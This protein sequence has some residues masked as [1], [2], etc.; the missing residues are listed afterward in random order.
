MH[1]L[2]LQAKVHVLDVSVVHITMVVVVVHVVMVHVVT[3]FIVT[4]FMS[5][6]ISMHAVVVV[7]TV[8]FVFEAGIIL[9]A[10][11]KVLFVVHVHATTEFLDHLRE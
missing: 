6:E 8:H 1:L 7:I 3:H 2:S 10:M 11:L 4:A 9:R 5:S